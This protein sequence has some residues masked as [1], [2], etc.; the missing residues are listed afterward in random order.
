[1]TEEQFDH[2]FCVRAALLTTALAE[3]A[4]FHEDNNRH[5]PC[6]TIAEGLHEILTEDASSVSLGDEMDGYEAAANRSVE[7]YL[8]DPRVVV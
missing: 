3:F 4:K 2:E 6:V 1:M 8:A 7:R 5:A